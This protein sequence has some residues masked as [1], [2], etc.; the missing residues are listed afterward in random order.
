MIGQLGLVWL[1]NKKTGRKHVN[2]LISRQLLIVYPCFVYASFSFNIFYVKVYIPCIQRSL[3][4]EPDTLE[5]RE[6]GG[7]FLRYWAGS[8]EILSLTEAELL[9][10]G[11]G[12]DGTGNGMHSGILISACGEVVK[13]EFD[14]DNNS[15]IAK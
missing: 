3:C 7:K 5:I 15:I 8:T 2:K 6:P 9:Y 10:S 14:E 13:L 11:D 4:C 1:T 12:N